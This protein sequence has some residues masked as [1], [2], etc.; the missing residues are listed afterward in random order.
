MPDTF[1]MPSK[2]EGYGIQ[3]P[4]APPVPPAQYGGPGKKSAAKPS[5][6]QAATN[7]EE[8][9]DDDDG[10]AIPNAELIQKAK[11]K[12]LRLRGAHMAPGYVPSDHPDFMAL[13]DFKKSEDRIK[14]GSDDD[15]SEDEPEEDIRMK[16]SGG[17]LHIIC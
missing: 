3:P 9:S 5:S 10:F 7:E 1:K 16:F 2:P 8:G 14:K 17:A 6:K 4:S 13:K 11:E 15:D 12:R